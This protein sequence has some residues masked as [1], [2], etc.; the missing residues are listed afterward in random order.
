MIAKVIT[1]ILP[2]QV[3]SIRIYI[4]ESHDQNANGVYVLVP[5][6][7]EESLL[8]FKAFKTDHRLLANIDFHSRS[9]TVYR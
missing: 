5:C 3:D 9:T 8:K 6:L 7:V 4:I 1:I 2:R